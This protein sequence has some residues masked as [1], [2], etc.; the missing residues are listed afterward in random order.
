MRSDPNPLVILAIVQAARSAR[1]NAARQQK[2]S[3]ALS[4]RQPVTQK[5]QTKRQAVQA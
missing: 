4:M 2:A 5:Q 3:V 1:K